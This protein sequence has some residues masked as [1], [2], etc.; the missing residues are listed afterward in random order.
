MVLTSQFEVDNTREK[1]ARLEERLQ[2]LRNE[3]GGNQRVRDLTK[4][5]L[6]RIIKQLKEE[7]AVYK[8]RH[9]ATR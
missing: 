1:L 2:A 8:A 3:N 7:I 4:A 6:S 5:S 9:M